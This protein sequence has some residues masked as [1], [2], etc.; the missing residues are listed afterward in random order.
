MCLCGASGSSFFLPAAAERTHIR[1][2]LR[3]IYDFRAAKSQIEFCWIAIMERNE[4]TRR[5]ARKL[6]APE[7]SQA[8]RLFRAT[9][10]GPAPARRHITAPICHGTNSRSP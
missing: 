9:L 5:L 2:V 10:L 8:C 4:L 7:R 3:A 6:A 1:Q